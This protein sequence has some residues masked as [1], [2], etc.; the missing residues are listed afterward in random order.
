MEIRRRS[1][2]LIVALALC[3]APLVAQTNFTYSANIIGYNLKVIPA[4]FSMIANHWSRTNL[5]L[6]AL[7]P[8]PPNN[9]TV[10]KFNGVGY[11]SERFLA[12]RWLTTNLVVNPGDGVFISAP[13]TFTNVFSGDLVTVSTNPIP[14]GFSIRSSV[15][16]M[17]GQL[18]ADLTYTPVNGD[19][20]YF[21]N[22]SGYNS[23]RYLANMWLGGDPTV[24]V[25]ESFWINSAN[26]KDW[27]QSYS[28]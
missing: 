21:Y 3:A 4:G 25:G 27:V 2:I 26:A 12:G 11:D 1:R 19:T 13:A 6:P 24:Q 10:Y 7:I 16:P 5:T 9:T 20:I 18:Q 22:G 8:S 28:P 17:Q 14:A 15:I 23:A